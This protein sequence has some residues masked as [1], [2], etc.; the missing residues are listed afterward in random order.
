MKTASFLSIF[1]A[2]VFFGGGQ[3]QG[4]E[5]SNTD[6]LIEGIVEDMQEQPLEGMYVMI[7]GLEG[8]KPVVSNQEGYFVL[9]IPQG[10]ILD[11]S[12]RLLVFHPEAEKSKI[13]YTVAWKDYN[14]INL[15]VEF[16]PRRVRK[17]RIFDAN[18]EPAI[19]VPI[20]IDNHLYISNQ[21]GVCLINHVATDVS[22]FYIEH[23]PQVRL[24]YNYDRL[25]M[26]VYIEQNE[27]HSS[28]PAIA[29]KL[30]DLAISQENP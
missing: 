20:H 3:V 13:N 15:K 9:R 25:E 11:E 2:F 5:I 10:R 4:Q 27:E 1:Y 22:I 8:I 29:P 17:V 12:H 24:K 21:K 28:Q 16:V 19:F 30:E 18:G 14:L 23:F 7:M 26:A 6:F